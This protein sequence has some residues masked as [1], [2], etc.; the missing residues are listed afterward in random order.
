MKELEFD[1][2]EVEEFKEEFEENPVRATLE[3]LDEKGRAA[4]NL[5]SKHLSIGAK[6]KKGYEP[7]FRLPSAQR[8]TVVGGANVCWILYRESKKHL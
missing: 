1:D 6:A 4:L 8:E 7:L 2:E 5:Y 3:L